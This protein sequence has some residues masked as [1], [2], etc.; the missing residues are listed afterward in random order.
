MIFVVY[1]HILEGRAHNNVRRRYENGDSI[2][3][4]AMEKFA[5]L[6]IN[7]RFLAIFL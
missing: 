3:V 1:I 7:A 2:V 4:E 6:A 5:T